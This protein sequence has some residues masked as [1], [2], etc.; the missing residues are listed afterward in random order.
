[1]YKELVPEEDSEEEEDRSKSSESSEED[2][3]DNLSD[4]EHKPNVV[5]GLP[6][7]FGGG[8]PKPKKPDTMS[9]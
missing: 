1:M 4:N 8:I 5:G 7:G 2:F 6:P 3:Y 9:E